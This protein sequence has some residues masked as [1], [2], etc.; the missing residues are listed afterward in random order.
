MTTYTATDGSTVTVTIDP[1][2]LA[3][4]LQVPHGYCVPTG[5]RTEYLGPLSADDLRELASMW[6]GCWRVASLV[7][8]DRL[9]LV[10]G[11]AVKCGE[12]D[13]LVYVEPVDLTPYWRAESP[14][15]FQRGYKVTDETTIS[16]LTTKL[17]ETRRE[18][19]RYDDEILRLRHALA[20]ANGWSHDM[21]ARGVPLRGSEE[22]FREAVAVRANLQLAVS[23]LARA[24][25]V[26]ERVVAAEQAV[27]DWL[28]D[29]MKACTACVDTRGSWRRCSYHEGADDAVDRA[30]ESVERTIL[31]NNGA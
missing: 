18:L 29:S 11:V 26:I 23:E 30:F 5:Q 12:G 24:N 13:Y 9:F 22:S 28:T 7:G 17:A 31:E 16:P 6:G 3:E 2:K 4:P 19:T 20:D 10:D 15:T 21:I 8:S 27:R 14:K 25:A 1:V